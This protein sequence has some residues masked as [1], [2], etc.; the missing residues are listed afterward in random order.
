MCH[1]YDVPAV[2]LSPLSPSAIQRLQKCVADLD[3]GWSSVKLH[4]IHPDILMK[5]LYPRDIIPCPLYAE[6]L[7]Q[8]VLHKNEMSV[9]KWHLSDNDTGCTCEVLEGGRLLHATNVRTLS[10]DASER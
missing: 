6:P 8:Q 3:S 1:R 2:D 10:R 4:C 9:M 7:T 5:V